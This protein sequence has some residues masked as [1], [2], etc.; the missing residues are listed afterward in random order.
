MTR[1]IAGAARGRRLSTPSGE[2]TRPTSDRVREGVFSTLESTLGSWAGVQ[3][4][5]L[6]AGSGAVGLEAVSRGAAHATLVEQHRKT[7]G[8]ARGNAE[9]LGFG[10]VDVVVSRAEAFVRRSPDARTASDAGGHG[11]YDVVF[12]DPPYTLAGGAVT[13][14]LAGLVEHRR[15]C[16][17]AVVAVE[18]SARDPALQ[19]P[20]G[21]HG[22]RARRYGETVVWY[23]RAT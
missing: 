4:L 14:L 17:G 10:Q 16:P 19:W 8:V 2:A 12:L 1:I 22:D 20:D 21:L 3:V 11:C 5:D 7:A 23:G 13:A 18:R 15:L 9:A 6:F